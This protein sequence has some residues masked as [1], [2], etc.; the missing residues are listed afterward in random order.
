MNLKALRAFG[1]IVTQGSLAAAAKHLNLSQP[2]VSR[3]IS[4]LEEDLNLTLFYRTK[5]SL[6]LTREG[7]A[8]Y[9]GTKHIVVG[10]DEIPRIVEDLRQVD[11]QFKLIVTHKIAQGLISPALGLLRQKKPGLRVAVDVEA[12]IRFESLVGI[13]RF[14]LAIASLPIPLSTSA[15][16]TVPLYRTRTEILMPQDHPLAARNSITAKDL[17]KE[18]LIGLWK[19]QLW[20]QQVDEFMGAAGVAG[21][22]ALETRHVLM[23]CQLVRDGLGL[24]FVDRVTAQGI[25]LD[26]LALRPVKPDRWVSFG[27][28]SQSGRPLTENAHAFAECIREVIEKLRMNSEE[29]AA[30]IQPEH[31]LSDATA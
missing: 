1:I 14:D 29:N 4:Q 24:A 12:R 17:E 30:S 15:V 20:R 21:N 2:S 8:F 5:R 13:K 31:S 19:D 3:L 6:T 18:P 9:E 27:Y 26:G 25:S 10:I 11:Q 23:S 28:I 7:E 16:E 22:F